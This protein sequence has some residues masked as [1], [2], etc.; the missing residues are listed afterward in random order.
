MRGEELDK[1]IFQILVWTIKILNIHWLCAMGFYANMIWINFVSQGFK[2]IAG[3]GGSD[4]Y[5]LNISDGTHSH[6][7][8]ML[9]TQLNHM[10]PDGQLDNFCVIRADKIVSNAVSEK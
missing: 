7:F 5:R 2:K 6:T 1:P 9:A 8:A 10:I 4:R 3:Q